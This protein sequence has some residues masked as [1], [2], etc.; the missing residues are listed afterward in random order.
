MRAHALVDTRYY[1][2]VYPYVTGVIPGSGSEEEVLTLGHSSEQGAQD[3]AT[4]V[5]AHARV[6]SHTQ[7]ADRGRQA[8]SGRNAAIRILLMGEM[9]GSMHYV[10]THA[11]RMRRTVAAMCVDTPAAPYDLAGTEYTFYM[12]PHV[13][14]SYTDA[15]VLHVAELYFPKVER[16]WHWHEF[17]TGT[18]TYLAE[19]TVGIPTV[20]PYS[21]TGVVSHHNSEDT[22]DKV[23]SRSLRDL[24]I[25]NATYLYYLATRKMILILNRKNMKSMNLRATGKLTNFL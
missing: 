22:P 2:G 8:R 21:G 17:M 15:F 4:G 14:K 11:E 7:P 5:A 20:W 13:A 16:P 6:A 12:N 3:N 24:A 19:P 9:Y 23:D 10:S 25:V 18:D 1:S